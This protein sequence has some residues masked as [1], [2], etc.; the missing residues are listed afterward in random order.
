ME[1]RRTVGECSIFHCPPERRNMSKK[2]RFPEYNTYVLIYG[3]GPNVVCLTYFDARSA[4]EAYRAA[5]QVYNGNV[6]LARVVLNYGDT[7]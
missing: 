2:S 3:E 4:V 7:I 1:S 6:R 5:Y